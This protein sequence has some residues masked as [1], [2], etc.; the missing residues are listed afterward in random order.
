[1]ASLTEIS[2]DLRELVVHW[3]CDHDNALY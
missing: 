3:R 1:M 2:A